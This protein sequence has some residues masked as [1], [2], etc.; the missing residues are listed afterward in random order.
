MTKNQKYIAI[1]VILVGV[2]VFITSDFFKK[3][4]T[5][6]AD[7]NKNFGGDCGCNKITKD[8]AMMLEVEQNAFPNFA[9][10]QENIIAQRNNP[11]GENFRNR[12]MVD[13]SAM[14][15]YR[16]NRRALG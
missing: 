7:E 3:S 13:V 8:N 11:Y 12:K 9:G 1:A 2:G 15:F 14:P 6:D 5:D 10:K 16:R 4:D